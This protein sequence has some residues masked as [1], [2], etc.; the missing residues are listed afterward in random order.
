MSNM[1]DNLK[2]VGKYIDQP[3]FVKSFNNKVPALL[4]GGALAY[5]AKD[6]YKAKPQERK[7]KFIQS[8]STL[9]FTVGSALVATRGL[10]IGK[11]QLFEGL[12]E[13]PHTHKKAINSV[14]DKL[15]SKEN[16]EKAVNLVNKV[17]N[18]KILKLAEIKTLDKEL[19][20]KFKDKNMLNSIIPMAHSHNPFGELKQLSLLG[21]VP[22][23]GGITGGVIGDKLS[24]DDWKKK[25]PDKVKEGTYQY[26]NNIF[27]CNV[28]AGAG[29]LLVN[30][31][32]IKSK[33]AK[34]GIIMS[35]VAG[36]GLVAGNAVA[37][38]VGKN[39]I[40]PIFDKDKKDKHHHNHNE[41]FKDLNN[42]RHPEL[43]DLGLHVDDLASIGFLSGMKILGPVLPVLYSVSGYR[44]GEGYRN[45]SKK[46]PCTRA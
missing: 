29:I 26:L 40:N 27:L 41:M 18:N 28:G 35:G 11:K 31:L 24:K 7:K 21:L 42:E 15:R 5:C 44:S 30:K 3:A 4:I 1:V 34:F 8:F 17:K 16:S 33:A 10:K 39:V 23:L 9:F 38:F 6:T 45:G 12:L 46:S 36:A 20:S 43:V 32:K 22:V 19:K 37:N 25:F 13:M 2:Y 14:L